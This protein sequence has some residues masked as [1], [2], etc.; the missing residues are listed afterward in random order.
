MKTLG[1]SHFFDVDQATDD[2]P[3]NL[4]VSWNHVNIILGKVD[5]D[6]TV[7]DPWNHGECMGNHRKIQ[8]SELLQ[9]TQIIMFSS[10]AYSND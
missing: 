1:E 2:K 10:I 6:L 4:G 7:T 5:H 9:F 8:V 3:S